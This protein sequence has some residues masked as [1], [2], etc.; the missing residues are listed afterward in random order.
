MSDL[1][2]KPNPKNVPMIEAYIGKL[3]SEIQE[4]NE[5]AEL[6]DSPTWK[7]VQTMIGRKI[8]QIETELDDFHK[9]DD[10]RIHALLQARIDHK[11]FMA[12]ID[13]TGQAVNTLNK[14]L[15]E[16]ENELN[17]LKSRL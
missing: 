6:V 5:L 13:G 11:Y 3:K 7:K 2:K 4:L 8:S 15:T 16:A 9:N 12:L 1:Y 10:K 17:E 14:K